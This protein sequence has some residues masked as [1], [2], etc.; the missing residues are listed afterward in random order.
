MK[1]L[2]SMRIKFSVRLDPLRFAPPSPCP[3][4]CPISEVLIA[5]F[6]LESSP[7]LLRL[8]IL[9]HDGKGWELRVYS[10]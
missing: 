7:A 5:H 1:N 6:Y 2:R 8:G 3:S 4:R 9:S 10:L